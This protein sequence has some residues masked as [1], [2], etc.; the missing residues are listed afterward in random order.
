MKFVKI[1]IVM[2]LLVV[3]VAVV[4]WWRMS[5]DYSRVK[6]DQAKIIDITPMVRLCTIDFY[7]DVPIR[8]SVGHRHFFGKMTVTGSIGFDLDNMRQEMCGDTIVLT[9]PREE[10]SVEESTDKDSYRV[11]DTWSDRFWGRSDFTTIEENEIKSK[12]IARYKKKLYATGV[13]AEARKEAATN[14]RPMVEAV[15]GHPVIV[16]NH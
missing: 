6:M 9:L 4:L 8:A 15:T 13:V 14:L 5:P 12:V 3:V 16:I 10:I 11:I 7:E 1:S 2:S